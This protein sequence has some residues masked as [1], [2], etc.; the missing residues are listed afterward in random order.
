M[1]KFKKIFHT[2]RPKNSIQALSECSK[3][4]PKE[5]WLRFIGTF[6]LVFIGAVILYVNVIFALLI[7]LLITIVSNNIIL[8]Y[9]NKKLYQQ[10]IQSQLNLYLN[11]MAQLLSTDKNLLQSLKSVVISLDSPIKE[12]LDLLIFE[13]EHSGNPNKALDDFSKKYSHDMYLKMFHD[14]LKLYYREGGNAKVLNEIVEEHSNYMIAVDQYTR[15]KGY[16]RQYIY[17]FSMFVLFVPAIFLFTQRDMYNLFSLSAFGHIT[18][19]IIICAI[20]RTI[21]E[22][23]KDYL[24][25][26]LIDFN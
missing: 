17:F 8:I 20:L 6:I 9:R 18:N 25:D 7:A 2:I 22:T 14:Q 13:F 10:H 11:L 16:Y 12:D 24:N 4:T 5:Y 1:N 19:S 15:R 26:T 21:V 3:V 23:E